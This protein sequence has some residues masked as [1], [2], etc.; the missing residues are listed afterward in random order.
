MNLQSIKS[1]LSLFSMWARKNLWK[2]SKKLSEIRS[3]EVKSHKLSIEQRVFPE[4][5][6]IIEKINKYPKKIKFYVLQVKKSLPKCLNS[7]KLAACTM[8]SSTDMRWV[9][10]KIFLSTSSAKCTIKKFQDGRPVVFV[11]NTRIAGTVDCYDSC[12]RAG[13]RGSQRLRLA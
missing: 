5:W 9:A 1:F 3:I 10:G 4:T 6:S 7:K 8:F 11:T 12:S 13:E 2:L